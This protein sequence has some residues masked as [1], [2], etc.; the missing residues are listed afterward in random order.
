MNQQPTVRIAT[1]GP[2]GTN[3]E[4]VCKRY[5]E[6][7]DVK[8][9]EINFVVS[10]REAIAMLRARSID[11]ILQCAV[12]PETPQTLGENFRDVFAIDSFIS[13]SQEL[14]ILTRLDV[15]VPKTIGAL[16]PANEG[17]C[18]LTRWETKV[19]MKSLPLIFESLLAGE[20]D[21]GLVY[22]TYADKHPD[23]VRV[24]EV[25]GSPDDVWI[26]YGRTRA[27]NGKILGSRESGF[28]R[29]LEILRGEAARNRG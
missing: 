25:I 16:L 2:R 22:R 12:H 21:S 13:D 10:F 7:H 23:K 26:V 28:S 6:F 20:I 4:M 5:M 14:A 17:Y 9:Y 27:Y 19:S 24:E 11:Y 15:T 1:L 8:S 18:D 3:H 29:D